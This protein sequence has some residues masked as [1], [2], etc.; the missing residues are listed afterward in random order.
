MSN[1]AGETVA[2][3]EQDLDLL[4]HI[5][6]SFDDSLQELA[7]EFDLS[8]SAIHYRLNKHREKGVIENTR[9]VLNPESFGL[10]RMMVSEVYVTH[11]TGYSQNIG[12]QLASI[13][14]VT[15]VYYT[16]GDVD[17]IVVSRTQNRDQMNN[18]LNSIIDIN[19]V[20]ETSS[21]FVIQEIKT[22]GVLLDNL[23]DGGR[24]NLLQK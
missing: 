8:K 16:L 10:D 15:Q 17:F 22:D 1:R 13:P 6:Q 19:G 11:E 14:G 4:Q 2:F 7:D 18:L 24:Q 23:P 9:A 5:E 20:N 21:R 3:D 12:E